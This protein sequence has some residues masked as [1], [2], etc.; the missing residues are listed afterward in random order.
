MESN[1]GL[2]PLLPLSYTIY[3]DISLWMMWV[4]FSRLPE[5]S[6]SNSKQFTLE[7][8]TG[9]SL[10]MLLFVLVTHSSYIESSHNPPYR[11][12]PR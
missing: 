5:S 9:M 10:F 7:I 11:V 1:H 8:N 6:K 4:L 2:N 12:T 3:K